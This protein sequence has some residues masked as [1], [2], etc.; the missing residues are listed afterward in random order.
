MSRKQR[1]AHASESRNRAPSPARSGGQRAD[2]FRLSAARGL[3]VSGQ[4]PKA[5]PIYK[6]LAFDSPG[7]PVIAEE[8]LQVLLDRGALAE[9][10]V[11]AHQ[12]TSR[13]RS[14][15]NVWLQL[16]HVQQ[17]LGRA[18]AAVEAYRQALRIDAKTA[19]AW[20]GIAQVY[21]RLHRLSEAMDAID[22]AILCAPESYYLLHCRAVILRRQG[23][24]E[25]AAQVQRDVLSA[26][27]TDDAAMH[28]LALHELSQIHRAEGNAAASRQS[29]IE[30]K[31]AQA[32]LRTPYLRMFDAYKREV[33]T[34]FEGL[35]A[36]V[37]KDWAGG[38]PDAEESGAPRQAFIIGHPRS[39][40]TLTEQVVASHPSVLNLD[41]KEAFLHVEATL[42]GGAPTVAK[43]E[44]VGSLEHRRFQQ[45]Y[46]QET[47]R[48]LAQPTGDRMMI[49]KRPDSLLVVPTIV[50]MMPAARLL[51]VIRDPRDVCVSC[52]RQAFGLGVVSAQ[53]HTIAAT[54]R[55]YAWFMSHWL[56]LRKLLPKS[57]WHEV[58]YESL[59]SDC[60]GAAREMTDFL[61]LEWDDAVLSYQDGASRQLI[62][63]P[64]YTAVSQKPHTGAIGGWKMFTE[65]I[66]ACAPI[67]QPY[68]DALGYV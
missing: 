51:V 52:Y 64:S 26:A 14:H 8:L 53:F 41:E 37:V 23:I 36:Q 32:P 9:A 62:S 48:Y 16:G 44:G 63:T 13:F 29:L 21:E 6:S 39:G 58:R 55:Y 33:A 12:A 68:L 42:F 43:L 25:E 11:V 54:C 3:L 45:L 27:P 66:E 31:E 30:S 17:R 46:R 2:R 60:E 28:H 5:Y 56:M 49:D 65:E 34:R 18:D 38:V 4:F 24:L 35:D 57:M 67:L 1:R 7:D 59:V 20:A 10:E 61:G 50:R 47:R 40:T 15:G 19:H 22:Q